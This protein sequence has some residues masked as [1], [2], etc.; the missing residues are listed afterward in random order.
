I[1]PTFNDEFRRICE[2]R[3]VARME[4]IDDRRSYIKKVEA[5]RGSV[6]RQELEADILMAWKARHS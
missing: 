6:K 3:A 4:S 2:A 1:W 5:I